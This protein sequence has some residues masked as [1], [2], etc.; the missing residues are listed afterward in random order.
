VK[1]IVVGAGRE[2]EASRVSQPMAQITGEHGNAR[3]G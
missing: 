1:L 3:H 2:A